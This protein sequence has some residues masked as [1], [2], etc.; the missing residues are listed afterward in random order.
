[1]KN[2]LSIVS[3]VTNGHL[4]IVFLSVFL[5]SSTSLNAQRPSIREQ[6]RKDL[7]RTIVNLDYRW[8]AAS[9]SSIPSTALL[10]RS[11]QNKTNEVIS[12]SWS[13]YSFRNNELIDIKQKTIDSE[14]KQFAALLRDAFNEYYGETNKGKLKKLGKWI[15]FMEFKVSDLPL[16]MSKLDLSRSKGTELSEWELS[17]TQDL[18]EVTEM[19]VY[20]PLQEKQK[21]LTFKYL[22]TK[23]IAIPWIWNFLSP[24]FTRLA[25]KGGAA[26]DMLTFNRL[27]SSRFPYMK[28]DSKIWRNAPRYF[29]EE[30]TLYDPAT[31]K[32]KTG[33]S[34]AFTKKET[35]ITYRIPQSL[36]E[37]WLYFDKTSMLVDH[38]TKQQYKIKRI[39]GGYPLGKTLVLVGCEEKIVEFTLV[40][41]PVKKPMTDFT[42][43]NRTV[44]PKELSQK[45]P[46]MLK[47]NIMSDGSISRDPTIYKVSDYVTDSPSP[48]I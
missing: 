39:E 44:V 4:L 24:E 7:E 47:H 42:I 28:N 25:Q 1:M 5:F 22:A 30:L 31:Q 8:D 26:T 20:Q 36:R 12:Q 11:K 38:D 45:I 40:Y 48:L 27:Y 41:E 9:N 10:E 18:L 15:D 19:F 32:G 37:G 21:L 6:Q 43:E 23:A 33:M 35:R 2:R 14:F 29:P 3:G 34:I 13:L 17:Y 46:Y 16:K